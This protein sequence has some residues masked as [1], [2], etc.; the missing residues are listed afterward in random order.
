MMLSICSL[1]ASGT[2]AAL[3]VV[4]ATKAAPYVSLKNLRHRPCKIYGCDG[5]VVASIGK[6]A[7]HYM[8]LCILIL[9][10]RHTK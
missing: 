9:K 2:A 5:A 7:G 6:R 8:R 10:A 3:H 1:V 4:A